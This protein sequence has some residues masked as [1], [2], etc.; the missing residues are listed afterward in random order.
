LK[1][2]IHE[3]RVS[4][5]AALNF[6]PQRA[7]FPGG[8]VAST[9][10][11]SI[12]RHIH[13]FGLKAHGAGIGL[14]R[15]HFS[16]IIARQPTVGWFEVIPENF[17]GR[18]GYCADTLRKIAAHYRLI[19]HGVSLSIGSTDPL[20]LDH[21]RRLRDFC[22]TIHSP[23]FSDH[24][25]FTMV[26]HVNLD[27]LIPLP[28]TPETVQHVAERVKIARDILERPLLLENVTYYMAP[29]RS[30]MS[31]AEFISDVLETADCGLLLDVSN[32]LLNSKNHGYDPLRF[33]DALPLERVGQL[34][35]AGYEPHGGVLLD[36]HA[37]PVSPETWDLYRAVLERIGPTSVLIEW[38]ADIPPLPRLV[39]EAKV[40]QRLMDE[41]TAAK[42]VET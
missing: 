14:R 1:S 12:V 38:D 4:V 13:N 8:A 22:D 9:G 15:P 31:E 5:I 11:V 7:R 35:L 26:D 16:E 36:T 27:D 29:S 18:G 37:R 39:R 23:W 41:V 20:D 40:A 34:H 30:Q 19:A 6:W 24:L 10:E 33:I 42:A 32:V 2:L 28:F 17:L 21:V 25:C 3:V